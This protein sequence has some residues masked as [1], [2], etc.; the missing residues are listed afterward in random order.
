M[1]EYFIESLASEGR[2]IM[3]ILTTTGK[4]LGIMLLTGMTLAIIWETVEY[5]KRSKE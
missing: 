4:G 5:Y 2:I 3:E 1:S